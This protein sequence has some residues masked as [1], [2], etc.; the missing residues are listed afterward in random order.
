[1]N[2]TYNFPL[3]PQYGNGTFRRRVRLECMPGKVSAALEDD[4]HGFRLILNHDGKVITSVTAESLRIPGNTCLEAP[5][6]L[7][8]FVGCA[9]TADRFLFRAYAEPRS[10]CTHLH[11]LLWLACAQA[12]RYGQSREYDVSVPDRINGRCVA[13]IRLDGALVHTWLIDAQQIHEPADHHGKPLHKG[14]ARW[15][16]EAFS[17]DALEA[18]FVLQMAIFVAR[19]RRNDVEAMQRDYP[20]AAFIREPVCHSFQPQTIIRYVPRLGQMRDFT[21]SPE[22]LLKFT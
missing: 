6:L 12:L 8:G 17:G 1:M 21:N 22:R 11:D 7:A 9:L 5:A 4:Y 13:E 19:A 20:A 14:F 16:P 3:N 18:A 2:T 10:H 15:V